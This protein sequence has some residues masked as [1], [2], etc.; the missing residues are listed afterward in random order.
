[1]MT[2]MV[3]TIMLKRVTMKMVRSLL[4]LMHP[5]KREVKLEIMLMHCLQES[6]VSAY[7][8]RKLSVMVEFSAYYEACLFEHSRKSCFCF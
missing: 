5:W 2:M 6:A 8:H 1:M 4:K 3:V 7:A